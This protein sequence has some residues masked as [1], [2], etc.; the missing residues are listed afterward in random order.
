[1]NNKWELSQEI[2]GY[3]IYQQL[4]PITGFLV[5]CPK[6]GIAI[7]HFVYFQKKDSG[8]LYFYP[9]EY[10]SEGE[11][12]F[13]EFLNDQS[14]II[15]SLIKI[16]KYSDSLKNFALKLQKENL[17]HLSDKELL[18]WYK[19][20]HKF[21]NLLW[22]VAMIPNILEFENSF[23]SDYLFSYLSS[24]ADKDRVHDYFSVLLDESRESE[25]QRRERDLKKLIFYIKSNK[26]SESEII[27]DYKVKKFYK[28]YNYLTYNWS[29]PAESFEDFILEIKSLLRAKE[30]QKI[31]KEKIVF[32]FAVDKYHKKLFEILKD[33]IFSKSYR[34]ESSYFTYY[35]M[36][37]L[38][39]NIGLRLNLSVLQAQS[40]PPQEM[41]R[42]L[43]DKNYKLDEIND[44]VN[45]GLYFN[46]GDK[47]NFV[48]GHKAKKRL[49]KIVSEKIENNSSKFLRGQVAFPGRVKGV[50][51]V[52]NHKEEID[53]FEEGD[54]LVSSFTDPTLMFAIKKCGGIITDVGGMTC[55]AAIVSRELKKPCIIGTKVATSILKNGDEVEMDANQGIVKI[56]N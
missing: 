8:Y 27:K 15:N 3:R 4:A 47:I 25:Q 49:E 51:R 42:I 10:R 22:R 32:N 23:L 12:Y 30:K 19:E 55:H 50:V 52:I 1:M 38:F 35:A 33:I 44:F 24:N 6:Y 26:L 5:D 56:I 43:V 18:G 28:K 7:K 31:E 11:K 29:G 9:D 21:H 37:R 34:M 45:L 17:Q 16:F 39:Q 14:L 46:G 2:R 53:K 41:K 48:S 40:I 13:K 54:I 20:F 36:E